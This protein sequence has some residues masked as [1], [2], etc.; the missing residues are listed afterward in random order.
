MYFL[1]AGDPRQAEFDAG[2]V[3]IDDPNDMVGILFGR[4]P[5]GD[6]LTPEE[7]IAMCVLLVVAGNETTTNLMANMAV[8]LAERPD[9]WDAVAADAA[10]MAPMVEESIRYLSPVQGLFR[11]TLV[12]RR[13]G[14]HHDPGRREGASSATPRPTGTPTSGATPTS[15]ASTATPTRPTTP[16]T[17]PSH[18]AS[19]CCLGAHLARLEASIMYTKLIERIAALEVTGPITRGH[20]SVDPRYQGT[21]HV[22]HP[23]VTDRPVRRGAPWAW[24]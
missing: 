6:R 3:D 10:L 11:N 2:T 1:R 9:V 21:S 14:R 12:A 18:R 7:I 8:V 17:S 19:T 24:T 16:T 4:T 15:S 13:A 5:D 20:Q 23:P 22:G